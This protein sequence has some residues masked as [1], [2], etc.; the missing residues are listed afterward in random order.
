[1]RISVFVAQ[2][3]SRQALVAGNGRIGNPRYARL[4][5]CATNFTSPKDVRGWPAAGRLPARD[6]TIP[7]GVPTLLACKLSSATRAPVVD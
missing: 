2:T 3:S 1:M 6:A 4:E 7:R 5:T